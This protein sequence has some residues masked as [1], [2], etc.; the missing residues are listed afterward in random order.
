[1]LLLVAVETSWAYEDE[2]DRRSEKGRHDWKVVALR[3]EVRYRRQESDRAYEM[4]VSRGVGTGDG[5]EAGA[6]D[7]RSGSEAEALLEEEDEDEAVV[8]TVVFAR[9][10]CR[11]SVA[12]CGDGIEMGSDGDKASGGRGN[13]RSISLPSRARTR[14][15]IVRAPTSNDHRM[16]RRVWVVRTVVTPTGQVGLVGVVYYTR[17]VE[18]KER[19]MR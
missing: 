9:R 17:M 19:M 13:G 2:V 11:R 12:V 6:V 14:A 16:V 10:E 18:G 1:L 4:D 7:G 8:V 5:G 3:R 15:A